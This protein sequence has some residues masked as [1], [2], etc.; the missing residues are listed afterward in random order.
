DWA[1]APLFALARHFCQ[2]HRLYG[3]VAGLQVD[4]SRP[5]GAGAGRDLAI[6]VAEG[7]AYDAYGRSLELVQGCSLPVPNISR[8]PADRLTHVVVLRGEEPPW[9]ALQTK[10]PA[11]QQAV[12]VLVPADQPLH[13]WEVPLG[14]LRWQKDAQGTVTPQ[15]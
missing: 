6:R 11:P 9:R 1:H 4:L 14:G 2:V 13:E 12:V 7:V 8:P 15:L 3:V 5:D 10:V